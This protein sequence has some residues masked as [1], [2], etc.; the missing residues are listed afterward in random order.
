[1]DGGGSVVND[2]RWGIRSLAY[3]IKKYDQGFY[4]VLEWESTPDLLTELDHT[5]RLEEK[6]LRHMVIHLDSTALE[7]LAEMRA[8]RAERP[9]DDQ[10]VP[11]DDGDDDDTDIDTDIDDEVAEVVPETEPEVVPESE[12]DVEPEAEQ[13]TEPEA[14]EPS[15]SETSDEADPGDPDEVE[16]EEAEE[17]EK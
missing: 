12:P 7:E 15:E 4:T 3:P 1:E 5:L 17:E 13:E 10:V 6:V 2:D 8:K 14:M 16:T 9:S 11:F